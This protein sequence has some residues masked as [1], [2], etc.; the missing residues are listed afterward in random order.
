M[1][2]N[3]PESAVEVDV[4]V[5]GHGFEPLLV[6]RDVE[7]CLLTLLVEAAREICAEL[8]HQQGNAFGAAALVP[9]RVLDDKFG[10]GGPILESDGQT[11]RDRALVG[12]VVIARELR[13]LDA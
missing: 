1:A 9:D 6:E 10:E 7:N 2:W 11:I 5:D 12:I 8:L 3:P 4:G 13:V